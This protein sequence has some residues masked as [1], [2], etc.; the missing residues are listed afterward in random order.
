[1]SSGGKKL[2]FLL[3]LPFLLAVSHDVYF[4]YFSSDQKIRQVKQLRIDPE[5][6][7]ASDLGW[8]WHNY[9]P[10][11][12]ETARTMVEPTIWKAQVDPILQLPSMV[13]GIIP[14][15]IGCV[16]LILAFI[17]GVWPFSKYGAARKESKEDF[18]V[19]QN[20]KAKSVNFTKK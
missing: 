7:M 5:E 15:I 6:F 13:V 17:L 19:Y 9:H 14:F 4:N 12:L 3:F 16:F 11:S 1:M 18:V 2:L 20:A 10:A 8:I